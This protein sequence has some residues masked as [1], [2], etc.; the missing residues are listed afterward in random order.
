MLRAEQTSPGPV[1]VG[2]RFDT[3]LKTMGRTLESNGNGV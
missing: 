2:T 1:G 3:A